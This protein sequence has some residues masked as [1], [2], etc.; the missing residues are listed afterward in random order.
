M[1]STRLL[2]L[3]GVVIVT[4]SLFLIALATDGES[5]L[6]GLHDANPD[7]PG[8]IPTL[9]GGLDVWEQVLAVVLLVAAVVLALLPPIRAK[10][11]RMSALLT[12][13]I[14]LALLVSAIVKFVDAGDKADEL[15]GVFGQLNA[16]GAI[17]E[18]FSVGRGVGFVV[19]FVGCV[20]VIFGGAMGII[21]TSEE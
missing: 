17:P 4:V 21:G 2:S 20:L 19:L 12:A 11:N 14:G 10:L 16:A 18:A 15:A 5:Y 8:G 9:W 1:H 7:V 3:V 6:A 13:L